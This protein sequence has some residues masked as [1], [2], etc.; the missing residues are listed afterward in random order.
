MSVIQWE[1]HEGISVITIN[2]PEVYNALNMDA[3]VELSGVADRLAFMKETR[4]VII[5]GAGDKAFCAGADLKERRTFTEDQVR[6]YIH[7]IRE[8]FTKIERLPQPVIAAVNGVALGGGTELALACDLRVADES[9][10]FGLTEVSLGIIPGAGGTQRLPRLIGK[11]RAK[12][13]IFTAQKISAERAEE[14]GLV[15]RVAKRGKALETAM[16]LASIIRENA[17]LSLA[18]AKFAIDQGLE[19]DLATGL[20]LETKAYET[21][22]PTKDRLEGLEAFRQKRKPI[23]RGE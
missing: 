3:L 13:M 15:N 19:T 23:Y 22:I 21:L 14:I 1:N 18:Q 8:T 4:V 9:A 11:A 6:R 16:E 17:P 10:T 2:R 12:E 7:L 5:T 20:A